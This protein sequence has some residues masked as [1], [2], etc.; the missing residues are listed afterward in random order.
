MVSDARV[1]WFHPAASSAK[2]LPIA[3]W[4]MSVLPSGRMRIASGRYIPATAA[5]SFLL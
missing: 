1:I 3:A 5:A 2:A 4:P